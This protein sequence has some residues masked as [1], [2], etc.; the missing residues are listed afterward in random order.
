MDGPDIVGVV[1]RSARVALE[2]RDFIRLA[3]GHLV[4]VGELILHARSVLLI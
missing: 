3:V 1:P 2:F 4:R